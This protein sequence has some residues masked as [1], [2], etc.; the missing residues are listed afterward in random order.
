MYR[1]IWIVKV[2]FLHHAQ[3]ANLELASRRSAASRGPRDVNKG[4]LSEYGGELH[5]GN[6]R[7]T[8]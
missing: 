4:P 8:E 7:K 3:E 2:Y 1:L 5:N 6:L